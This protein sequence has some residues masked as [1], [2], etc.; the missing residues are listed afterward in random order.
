MRYVIWLCSR[1]KFQEEIMAGRK[2]MYDIQEKMYFVNNKGAQRQTLTQTYLPVFPLL[3]IRI[4][5]D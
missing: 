1:G 4:T 5:K 2:G 3:R